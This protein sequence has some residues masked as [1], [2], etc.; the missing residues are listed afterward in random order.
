MLQSGK[1]HDWHY[2]CYVNEEDDFALADE[3]DRSQN[4]IAGQ[5]RTAHRSLSL[6]FILPFTRLGRFRLAV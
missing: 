3:V 6:I 5:M 2:V 4:Q 1:G